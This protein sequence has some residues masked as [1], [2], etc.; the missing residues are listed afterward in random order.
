MKKIPSLLAI[1]LFIGWAGASQAAVFYLTYDGLEDGTINDD[2]IVG[3]GIFSYDGPAMAGSFLLSDLTGVSYS[4]TFTGNV[5]SVDFTGPPFDPAD[6]SLIGIE[7]MEVGGGIF[8]LI[9]SGESAGTSGSLDIE[10]GTGLLSHEPSFIGGGVS[11]R[12]F[13]AEDFS[14]DL[15]VF[16][17]YRATTA[18]PIPLPAGVW[19]FGSA[20]L[21]L[22]G[23][24]K[25]R[26]S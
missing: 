20:L 11:P 13:F 24:A 12:L 3:T 16:G 23:A 15:D 4:A 8:E 22:M 1:F 21:G 10:T 5:G 14:V 9:F 19:L 26:K 25:R 17:D 7:V 2:S 6:S 18:T